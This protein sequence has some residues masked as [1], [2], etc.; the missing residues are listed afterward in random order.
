MLEKITAEELV[1][2]GVIGMD[3]SP[4]LTAEEMQK[5][6]EETA[7]EVIVPKFNRL[8]EALTGESGAGEV[9]AADPV[10]GENVTVQKALESLLKAT[11]HT[12]VQ[13]L[14]AE[15]RQTAR[16]NIR[17]LSWEADALEPGQQARA[18]ANI[19][20]ASTMDTYAL[21]QNK[22]PKEHISQTPMYGKGSGM[23]YGHVLIKDTPDE[24]LDVSKGAAATPKALYNAMQSRVSVEAQELTEEQK[25]QARANIGAM[26]DA[27][28][29]EAVDKAVRHDKAQTL[30]DAQKETARK[31]IGAVNAAEAATA[32]VE[33]VDAQYFNGLGEIMPEKAVVCD[34]PIGQGAGAGYRSFKGEIDFDGGWIYT[35]GPKTVL[36]RYEDSAG[37][38]EVECRASY[39]MF[40]PGSNWVYYGNEYLFDSGK[41]NT[42]EDFLLAFRMGNFKQSNLYSRRNETAN[43]AVFKKEVNREYLPRP[44][45]AVT[46]TAQTLTDEQKQQARE[47]I[48]AVSEKDVQEM[49]EDLPTGGASVDEAL[50]AVEDKYFYEMGETLVPE[51][52]VQCGLVNSN[53]IYYYGGAGYCD[54]VAEAMPETV[55][56]VVNGTQHRAAVQYTNGSTGGVGWVYIGNRSLSDSSEADTGEDFLLSSGVGS[57]ATGITYSRTPGAMT[58]SVHT[59]GNVLADEYLNPLVI[60]AKAQALSAAMQKQARENIGAVGSEEAVEAV[61]EKFFDIGLAPIYPEETVT[62]VAGSGPSS[63]HRS[64]AELAANGANFYNAQYEKVSVKINGEV[65]ECDVTY[66]VVDPGSRYASVGN[67]YLYSRS[68]PDTGEDFLISYRLA[69]GASVIYTRE[70]GEYT[71][72]VNVAAPVMKPE[73]LPPMGAADAVTYTAQTLTDEQKAQARENIGAAAAGEGGGNAGNVTWDD[74]SVTYGDTVTWDGD[75][76]GRASYG[77]VYYKVSDAAPT[78]E[79]VVKGGRMKASSGDEMDF[80]AADLPAEEVLFPGGI[81]M[82]SAFAICPPEM[83]GVVIEG[84]GLAFPEAGTYFLTM[85]GMYICEIQINGYAGFANKEKIPQDRL[86]GKKV[87]Y[88]NAVGDN[89]V[90]LYV[91]S[92]CSVKATI[93][94]IP[95]KLE[96]LIGMAFPTEGVAISL[97]APTSCYTM[98]GALAQKYNRI[99]FFFEDVPKVLYTAEYT[100]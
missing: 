30:T 33:A 83:A 81:V 46:Y 23:A 27:D 37:V 18:R 5:K 55:V 87:F 96:F 45:D 32:G 57:G 85:D 40:D 48:G 67:M 64:E 15:Q 31:N 70:P 88:C 29:D 82:H 90:Y 79:E 1:G 59:A 4:K 78:Y 36:V 99:D 91:D 6:F 51:M 95:E 39:R 62:T 86:P 65:V 14:T 8:I 58:F 3:D 94:D 38:Q 60:K 34:E 28:V 41:P 76:S 47:N 19:G 10:T 22:A 42:G 72:T 52:T 26:G 69:N 49:L 75:P 53:G 73:Y 17:A 54:A 56:V 63:S 71:F 66:R 98:T 89:D 7:R 97:S 93:N 24:T 13:E 92:T 44:A 12:V 16:D 25:K 21:E 11:V 43:V 68:Y 80:T 84:V 74:I 9:G 77:E 50:K 20:A 61:E 35:E 2:K 100:G